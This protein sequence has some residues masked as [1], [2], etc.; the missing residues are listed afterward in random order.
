M[1]AGGCLKGQVVL[2]PVLILLPPSEEEAD[3]PLQSRKNIPTLS[4][5]SAAFSG[6]SIN[7]EPI[8]LWVNNHLI[9]L[10]TFDPIIE[11]RIIIIIN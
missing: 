10:K 8:K 7:L 11:Q 6:N 1:K 4:I 3:L 5:Q 2:L 9:D